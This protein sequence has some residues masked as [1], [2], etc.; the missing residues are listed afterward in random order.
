MPDVRQLIGWNIGIERGRELDPEKGELVPT[1]ALVYTEIDLKTG[2][3]TG[4][5][6]RLGFREHVRD[7]IVQGLTSGIVI[8]SNGEVS[9]PH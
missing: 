1:W 3:P 8:A 4:N 9:P 2:H 5:I 6:I 7:F